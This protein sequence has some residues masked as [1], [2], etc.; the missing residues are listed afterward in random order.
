MDGDLATRGQAQQQQ[1]QP[2]AAAAA[3]AASPPTGQY[4]LADVAVMI[5]MAAVWRPRINSLMHCDQR[6]KKFL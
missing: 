3:A 5:A 2:A 6:R 4:T 1:Q